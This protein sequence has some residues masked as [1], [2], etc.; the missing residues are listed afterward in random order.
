MHTQ[1]LLGNSVPVGTKKYEK[2]VSWRSK[3]SQ[4]QTI[5]SVRADMKKAAFDTK[6]KIKFQ[7][8]TNCSLYCALRM[9]L[10]IH[11]RLVFLVAHKT[12]TDQQATEEAAKLAY[13]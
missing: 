6:H 2:A 9:S 3:P 8:V 11:S 13:L 12:S 4:P 7:F 1:S 5:T 10:A